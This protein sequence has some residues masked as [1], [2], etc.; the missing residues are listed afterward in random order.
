MPRFINR[1]GCL[2]LI[3]LLPLAVACAANAA[4]TPIEITWADLI[5]DRNRAD[6]NPSFGVVE[7]GQLVTP[8]P[9]ESAA[10]VTSEYNGKT[11]RVPGFI[12]PL[13]YEGTG[14]RQFLLVPYVGACIHV[15]P[16]PA[17]Q[18][19]FVTA[20]TPHELKGM[21]D[22][23]YVTGQ[24]GTAATSTELAEVGYQMSADR[25]EPYE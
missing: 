14:T 5:P 15:P 21:F 19:I 10:N 7:H 1:R 24:F 3:G 25:I 8:I 6:D 4:E 23:V 2:S 9:E 17:N 16:P 12:V 11:V 22:P 13:D 20:D 18:L